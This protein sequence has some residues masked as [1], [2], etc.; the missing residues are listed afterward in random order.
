MKK[1]IGYSLIIFTVIF[2]ILWLFTNILKGDFN[3]QIFPVIIIVLPIIG[4]KLLKK[5]NG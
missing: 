2:Y 1:I 5:T 4:V 3:I